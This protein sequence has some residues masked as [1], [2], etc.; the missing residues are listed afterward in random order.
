ML[1]LLGKEWTNVHFIQHSKLDCYSMFKTIKAIYGKANC[2]NVW[3]DKMQD[4]KLPLVAVN[5][6]IDRY[7]HNKAD[8]NKLPEFKIAIKEV[9]QFIDESVLHCAVL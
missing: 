2:I 8:L 4:I 6:L 1:K 5:D 7:I 9:K 3:K